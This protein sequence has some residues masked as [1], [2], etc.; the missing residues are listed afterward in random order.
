MELDK[1]WTLIESAFKCQESKN[2]YKHFQD[3]SIIIF[4]ID[5]YYSV[6][7]TISEHNV[8]DMVIY[9]KYSIV[10]S[11]VYYELKLMKNNNKYHQTSQDLIWLIVN[12][13]FIPR[14]RDIKINHFI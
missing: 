8:L 5:N 12:E 1:L 2:Y 13:I 3:Q 11:S 9:K 6:Q 10:G 4:S 7:C 14:L